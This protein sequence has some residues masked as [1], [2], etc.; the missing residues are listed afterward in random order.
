MP[1]AASAPS[2]S[3]FSLS[4]PATD[5]TP[6]P[7]LKQHGFRSKLNTVLTEGSVRVT[8]MLCDVTGRSVPEC[9]NQD[10]PCVCG[11]GSEIAIAIA[12]AIG[13]GVGVGI[14]VGIGIGIGYV[15]MWVCGYVGMWVCGY[16]GMWVCGYVGAGATPRSNVPLHP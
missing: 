1:S 16:V 13:I 14:G 9:R 5:E 3:S 6:L 8:S 10:R 7:C 15:G 11:Y 2:L 12:I 4:L